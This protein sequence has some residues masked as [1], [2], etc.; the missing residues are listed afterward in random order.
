MKYVFVGDIHGKIE[1]VNQAIAW[2]LF[3]LNMEYQ[4]QLEKYF[5]ERDSS[6]V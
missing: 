1:A 2:T 3:K 4:N 5:D 6:K